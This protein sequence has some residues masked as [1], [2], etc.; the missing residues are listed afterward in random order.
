MT[1]RAYIRVSTAEQARDGHS[2]TQQQ[3][4][5]ERHAMSR[6]WTIDK[7]YADQGV[8]SGKRRPELDQAMSD[9][10]RGDQL[11]ALR[12]DR[13]CRSTAEFCRHI[14]RATAGGWS[15][16]L[17]DQLGMDMTTPAG[18]LMARTLAS[19]AEFERDM[20]RQ[21]TREGL[22]GAALAGRIN[23]VDDQVRERIA[24]LACEQHLSQRKIAAQLDADGFVPPNGGAA[25]SR[26]TV[27]RVLQQA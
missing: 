3:A 1:T 24:Y 18:K 16:I 9:M 21:R 15:M 22:Q 13:V 4:A 12:L 25:W 7:V 26:A 6:G 19:F 27:Q 14:E 2:L 10:R 20:V 23:L 17:L 5:L 11:L 8:S